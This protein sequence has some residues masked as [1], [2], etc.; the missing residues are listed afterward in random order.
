MKQYI[1]FLYDGENDAGEMSPEEMQATIARY[2]AWAQA[3]GESGKYV[4][5][6]KL[7]DDGGRILRSGG[8]GMIVSDGPYAETKDVIGGYFI[9]R[10]ADYA[11][12]EGI[13]RTCPHAERGKTIE[14]RHLEYA[15]G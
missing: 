12:A 5:G 2:S 3:L 9:I 14:I 11:E 6:E 1:L 4:G 8:G 13:A 15:E 10:A 7:A